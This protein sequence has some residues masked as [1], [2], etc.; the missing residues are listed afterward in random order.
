MV[1]LDFQPALINCISSVG[2]TGDDISF[3]CRSG[4]KGKN[5]AISLVWR[6]V[7][8]CRRFY[9]FINGEGVK[10][11]NWLTWVSLILSDTAAQLLLKKGTI[12]NLSNH[13]DVN[14]Y[15]IAG[16]FLYILSFFLWMQILKTTPLYIALSGA[17]IIFI[18]IAF[19]SH[20]FLGEPLTLKSLLGTILVAVGV[21]TVG[22][23]RKK[24]N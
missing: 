19:G 22:Y 8:C 2:I 21:Y 20:L 5:T 4:I 24:A 3:I 7:N 23:S 16:Y 18:T 1:L 17:S 10:M 11:L 15:I 9:G 14:S 6:G 12:E 13:W